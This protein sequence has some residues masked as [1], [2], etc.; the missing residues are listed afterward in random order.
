VLPRALLL[1]RTNLALV[2]AAL[3]A[4]A[5]AGCTVVLGMPAP[6][7]MSPVDPGRDSGGPPV[8][9]AS[10][11]EESPAMEPEAAATT[12]GGS[13]APPDNGVPPDTLRCGGGDWGDA[14]FC[15]EPGAICCMRTEEAGISY[16]C[17]AG[18][19]C[20]HTDTQ[21][22]ITCAGAQD[23]GRNS[24]CCHYGSHTACTSGFDAGVAAAASACT[25]SFGSVVCD[26][27]GAGTQC[28]TGSCSAP[29]DPEHVY[30]SC[31]M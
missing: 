5:A 21:Y 29:L 9:E 6:T 7:E 10:P 4:A 26:R 13:D 22:P 30:W 3:A 28:P 12:D 24:V 8:I 2:A 20:A 18:S 17:S 31:S 27:G 16:A 23:C 11:V 25:K 15:S 19:A 14:S 1:N